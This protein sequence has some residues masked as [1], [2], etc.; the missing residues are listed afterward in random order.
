MQ[1]K[2]LILPLAFLAL[3][4][5]AIGKHGNAIE[6]PQSI[7]LLVKVEAGWN[8]NKDDILTIVVPY[9]EL[10]K[11]TLEGL[12]AQTWFETAPDGRSHILG[13]VPYASRYFRFRDDALYGYRVLPGTQRLT[14]MTFGLWFPDTGFAYYRSGSSLLRRKF[15]L[16]PEIEITLD[17]GRILID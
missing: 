4:G 17:R 15:V 5:C 16:K 8:P 7:E 13:D 12:D 11:T 14:E 3:S 6:R 10:T 2:S 1:L 9:S